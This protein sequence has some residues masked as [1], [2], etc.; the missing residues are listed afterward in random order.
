MKTSLK[1]FLFGTAFL[2]LL[3]ASINT[4]AGKCTTDQVQKMIGAGFSKDEIK[5]LC[6]EGSN[7]PTI[8]LNGQWKL[9]SESEHG[10]VMEYWK[11]SWA[12]QSLSIYAYRQSKN[13]YS[14]VP[15]SIT[16][17]EVSGDKIS[18]TVKNDVYGSTD[19]SLSILN[20]EK[21][22][23]TFSVTDTFVA[24][25][26]GASASALI[27]IPTDFGSPQKYTGPVR[28]IRENAQ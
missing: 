22:E 18:F 28:L 25:H 19:Y 12:N 8:N 4:Y 6:D 17:Q 23:G 13:Q 24:D 10:N 2:S 11:L 15:L 5:R 7:G 3:Q 20:D 26:G 16:R 21:I 9:I 1:L 27:S 14:W